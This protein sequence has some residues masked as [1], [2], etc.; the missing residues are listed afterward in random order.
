VT[1]A[2]AS[3]TFRPLER[4][5][6]GLLARWL[7]EPHVSAWWREPLDLAGLEAKYGPRIDGDEPVCMF[8]IEYAGRP[9]GWIQW[10]RW[11]DYGTHARK[12]GATPHEVGLDLAIGDPTMIGIGLGPLVL[13]LFVRQEVFAHASVTAVVCDPEVLNVRSR[14]AFEKAGFQ[15]SESVVLDGETEA[16]VIVRLNRTG[17][18]TIP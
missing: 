17:R 12:L 11:A 10:Y 18:I 2:P 16:R 14:R 7:R 5:D 9:V 13:E 8:V 15:S 4:T 1:V 3:V 6:F